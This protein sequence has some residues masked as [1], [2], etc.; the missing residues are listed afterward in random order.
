M[1]SGLQPETVKVCSSGPTSGALG[2]PQDTNRGVRDSDA[3]TVDGGG[4]AGAPAASGEEGGTSDL[5]LF[6]RES[7]QPRGG[8][9]G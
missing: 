8:G 5:P 2:G 4:R 1:T 6:C 7:R 9:G 3:D